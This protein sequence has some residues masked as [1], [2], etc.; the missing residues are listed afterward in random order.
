MR[1]KPRSV[2]PDPL[3]E[4]HVHGDFEEALAALLGKDTGVFDRRVPLPGISKSTL[5]LVARP[6][7]KRWDV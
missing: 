4:G 7:A 3:P 5:P 1:C 6:W 2:D